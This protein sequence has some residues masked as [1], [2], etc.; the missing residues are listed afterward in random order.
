MKRLVTGRRILGFLVLA[1]IFA[2]FFFSLLTG[3]L[4]EWLWMK[5]LGYENIFWELLAIKLGWFGLAFVLTFL[6]FWGNLRL[7]VRNSLG[8]SGEQR[9][10]VLESGAQFTPQ[11]AKIIT[12]AVPCI[13]ALIFASI[14]YSQW[15]TYLRYRWGGPFGLPDPIFGRDVGFYIFRLPFYELIQSSLTGLTFIAFLIILI[16]YLFLGMLRWGAGSPRGRN[17][18]AT[19]H[20]SILFL[21]SV[22]NWM[23]GYYLDRFDLLY[24]TLGVVYGVGY[25]AYHV[26]RISLWVM[27][28]ASLFLV[29]WILGNLWRR[30][31]KMIL[32]GVGGYFLLYF[33]VITLLPSAVQKFTVQPSEL[34][35]EAPYL[36]HNI[37]FTRRAFQLDKIEVKIVP[38]VIGPH[39]RA[40]RQP[41]GDHSEHPSLGLAAVAANLPA[42]AGDPSLLSILRG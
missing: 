28:F 32:L 15:D 1:V 31:G 40:G 8:G 27:I 25:T 16:A 10:L 7:V 39:P 41:P 23:W 12:L 36:K 21:L 5:E 35:L 18:N 24:S 3:R 33:V 17:W 37:D 29:I 22:G 6:Y 26:T 11:R 14:Y 9:I 34:E 42:N 2:L 38:R 20:V 19:V 4:V 30:Q 13:P